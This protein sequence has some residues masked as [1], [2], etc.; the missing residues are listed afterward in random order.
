[1]AVI[2]VGH[3]GSGLASIATG[4]SIVLGGAVSAT[5]TY[6]THWEGSPGAGGRREGSAE[7]SHG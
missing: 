5:G 6:R 4:S 1:M 3:V 2:T 7:L